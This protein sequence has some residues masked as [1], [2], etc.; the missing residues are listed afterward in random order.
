MIG[1]SRMVRC[2]WLAFGKHQCPV[3]FRFHG[4]I[5]YILVKQTHTHSRCIEMRD[6]AERC[7]ICTRHLA[8]FKVLLVGWAI[9]HAPAIRPWGALLWVNSRSYLPW[10]TVRLQYQNFHRP[11]MIVFAVKLTKQNVDCKASVRSFNQMVFRNTTHMGS[12]FVIRTQTAALHQ[13]LGLR[14]M[15]D[16]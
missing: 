12:G 13:R 7:R 4:D 5:C 1:R 8:Q 2:D 14:W 10:F 6:E 16:A 9:L 15:I 11:E 3:Q